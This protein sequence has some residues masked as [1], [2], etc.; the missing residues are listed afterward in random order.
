MLKL[1]P[2]KSYLWL[3]LLYVTLFF[4][5]VALSSALGDA[6][7]SVLTLPL[8]FGYLLVCQVRSGVALD[9]V[10]RASY[11]KGSWDYKL[12]IVWNCLGVVLTS[13]MAYLVIAT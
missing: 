8:V 3:F 10:W 6:K 7:W 13:V 4:G 12:L 9:R 11:L 1:I 2:G 5:G